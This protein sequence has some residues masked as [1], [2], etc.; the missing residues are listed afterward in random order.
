[1]TR[2]SR[3]TP[4]IVGAVLLSLVIGA[5]MWFLAISPTRDA[6]AETN[7]QIED[8]TARNDQLVVQN[9]ALKKQFENIEDY[10][11]ELAGYR[12]GIPES[13]D[14][15]AFT[16][17]LGEIAEATGAFI[18][19]IEFSTSSLVGEDVSGVSGLTPN[20]LGS[21]TSSEDGGE[22]VA[23]TD[24][25]EL[26]PEALVPANAPAGLFAIP[27][28]ITILGSPDKIL[29]YLDSLQTTTDRLFY[30]ATMDL[31]GQEEAGASGG[32]PEIADGDGEVVINGYVY[33]L[34]PSAAPAP[35]VTQPVEQ[36]ASDTAVS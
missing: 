1:M 12:I 30:L 4:W 3:T 34:D 19:D 14:Q 36:E 10:R 32:K 23:P 29:G 22:D 27:V 18:V 25:I 13:I 26:S 11:N 2:V 35:E 9:A 28:K 33:V 21:E 20:D 17:E 15:S 8:Q 31:A 5:M 24:Q 16:R 6:L 7:Q